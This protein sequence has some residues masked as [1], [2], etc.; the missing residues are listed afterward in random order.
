MSV[1]L[2]VIST[3]ARDKIPFSYFTSVQYDL[4]VASLQVSSGT[5]PILIMS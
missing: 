4:S 3:V 1:S 5:V 2:V